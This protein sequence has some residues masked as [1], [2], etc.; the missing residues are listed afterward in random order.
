M[1]LNAIFWGLRTG[2]PWRDLPAEYGPWSTAWDFLDKWTKDWTFDA[3]L[4]RLRTLAFRHDADPDELWC[5][6]GTSIRAAR[7]SAG[8]GK[9]ADPDS[10]RQAILSQAKHC[11]VPDRLAQ[12]VATIR[13]QI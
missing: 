4:C 11:R 5:I 9:N 8:G 7:C 3:M 13:N 1:I 10:I 2:A 12:R 6:D